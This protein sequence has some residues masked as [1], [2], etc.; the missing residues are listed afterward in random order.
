MEQCLKRRGNVNMDTTIKQ[1]QDIE[2]D[3]LKKTLEIIEK[4]NLTYYMLGGTL[5]G[6]VRHQGFI[7]WDDDI[8]IGLPRPDY[9]K[10]LEY[11]SAELYD[12]YRLHFIKENN[13]EYYYYYARVENTKVKLLRSVSIKET[14]VYAWIDVFPL[15][16]V[17]DKEAERKKWI[18][19]CK[20]KLRDF[21]YSQYSYFAYP[22]ERVKG[23]SSFHLFLRDAFSR[24]KI[25]KLIS[26]KLAW[27]RLD[28]ALK[29]YNFEEC[30]ALINF[31]G[32]WGLK[33]M[34]EKTVYGKGKLYQFEDIQLNG[35][36]NYDFVLTQMYGDYMTPPPDADK[37][38]HHIEMYGEFD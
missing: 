13:S 38:Q 22:G 14:E 9:E 1:I 26:T 25:E 3:I 15:D 18:I 27:K 30:N 10:F 31:C 32:H 37:N 28:K 5:L 12:P 36:E 7:P 21:S 24:L 20:R 4:H 34:F 17:S 23:R 16:G 19:D 6:A 29:K 2:L 8:D 35:P 11:A 33:E